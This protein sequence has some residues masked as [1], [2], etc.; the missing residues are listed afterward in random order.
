MIRRY[1]TARM[2]DLF[3]DET[4]YEL[5]R[6]I[7]VEAMRNSHQ[8]P[9]EAVADAES[10]RVPLGG[11]TPEVEAHEQETGHDVVAFIDV[12]AAGFKHPGRARWLH[13]G[14]TSSDLV[15]TAL[16]MQVN[17]ATY[18]VAADVL[19][20]YEALRSLAAKHSRTVRLGRTHG[21]AADVTTFG[22]Q[23]AYHADA[24]HRSWANLVALEVPGKLSGPVG[25]NTCITRQEERNALAA[26]GVTAAGISS[27]VVMRDELARVVSELAILA[28]V[29]DGFA[30]MVRLGS[31][32]EIGE[33]AEGAAADRVGSSSM[34]HK[35][36]PVTSEKMHGLALLARSMVVPAMQNIALWNERDISNSSVERVHIPDLFN[37]MD[38][39]VQ[40]LRELISRLVVD[41]DRMRANV[42]AAEGIASY[43]KTNS[44]IIDGRTRADA[45]EQARDAVYPPSYL[46]NIRDTGL[47]CDRWELP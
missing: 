35:K 20:A 17:R 41:T 4:R 43:L 9:V 15:D 10:L 13:W 11:W 31:Q 14:L 16:A 33:L 6:A 40:T 18:W 21:Q 12:M 30:L 37:L 36:N 28:S 29:I 25:T 46:D 22:H 2:A 47:S 26:L 1:S 24:L 3:S 7:E 5:W 8:V 38:H 42:D 19:T 23:L 32:T 45:R 44:L 27:Q 34:P 39:L